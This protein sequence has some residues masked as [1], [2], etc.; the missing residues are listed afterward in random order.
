MQH[1]ATA[2]LL[3]S[4]WAAHSAPQ[5]FAVDLTSER[6]RR[7]QAT[8][9]AL[10]EGRTLEELLGYQLERALHDKQADNLISSL[11]QA[12][13]LPVADTAN[14]DTP[15]DVMAARADH[16]RRLIV[17]GDAARRNGADFSNNQNLTA[18][19]KSL[20]AAQKPLLE[21]LFSDLDDTVDAMGDVLLA[22]SVHQL[23]GGSSLR[24]GLTADT[25]GRANPVPER[26]DVLTT[27][28]D[29]VAVT[30]TVGFAVAHSDAS[31]SSKSA[32]A[33]L[34]PAANELAAWALGD[35]GAWRVTVT[36]PGGGSDVCSLSDLEIAAIDAVVEATEPISASALAARI[37]SHRNV[38]GTVQITRQDGLGGAGA[39]S[40]LASAVRA[41]LAD[42]QPSIPQTDQ[43]AP[44]S[45]DTA[46]DL[47]GLV[48]RIQTWWAAISTALAQW[49]NGS[50]QD[51]AAAIQQLAGL[52]LSG[53][54]YDS[55]P[56]VGADLQQR[57]GA[58]TLA[59][60]P[61]P[62]GGADIAAWLGRTR[63]QLRAA[64]GDWVLAA[65]SWSAADGGWAALAGD[66]P[67][68]EHIGADEVED[69]L[70]ERRDV[71]AAVTRLTDGLLVAG[72][73]GAGTT[74]W[75]VRQQAPA[76]AAA[77]TGWV[78]RQHPGSR[79]AAHLA[80]LRVGPLDGTAHTLLAVDRW[81]EAVPK[82]PRAD[83]LV[84]DQTTGLG[85][86]F[87]RP[88][89]RAPQ[90]LLLVTA[91]DL[92]RGWCLEDLHA[93]V[94]ETLWWTRA[95]PL[96]GDDLPEVAVMLSR[97]VAPT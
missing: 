59:P 35:L 68:G 4:G 25:V 80:A 14:S 26:F 3:H 53:V 83:A 20:L 31:A 78:A 18:D 84:P 16:G 56:A 34:D 60:T 82:M 27:P 12:C 45:A 85:F 17:D 43:L 41:L 44:L 15:D 92:N 29:H 61:P 39:L 51:Q 63:D 5:A 37:R 48:T 1:A 58:A 76:S 67:S 2:A 19:Q 86:R 47:A 24:A 55:P 96:D 75:I 69:W 46:V 30:H 49:P 36:S 94:D 65:P 81:V 54:R 64:T 11:R 23:V 62:E 70:A 32:R 8:L 28:R 42:A 38:D 93:A 73:V 10:R 87:D 89:A 33:Q 50:G 74:D 7:A 52:G 79:S 57:W 88:D 90:A 9:S 40:V 97:E 13:P 77:L 6:V 71:C 22:E 91:P 72:A 21:K 95:R 66:E